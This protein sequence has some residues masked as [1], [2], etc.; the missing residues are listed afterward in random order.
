MKSSMFLF[1]IFNQYVTGLDIHLVLLGILPHSPLAIILVTFIPTPNT[2]LQKSLCTDSMSYLTFRP[3]FQHCRWDWKRYTVKKFKT[4]CRS[5]LPLKVQCSLVAIAPLF[6][7]FKVKFNFQ[8]KSCRILN[9]E[10]R[11]P[12]V[13]DTRTRLS[14]NECNN[15]MYF[16]WNACMY[17]TFFSIMK[18]IY[19]LNDKHWKKPGLNIPSCITHV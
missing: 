5:I 17:S 19:K 12:T 16:I 8:Q 9:L 13:S 4:D 11:P 18:T 10:W 1:M 7:M 2:H 14:A 3:L 6:L 15:L